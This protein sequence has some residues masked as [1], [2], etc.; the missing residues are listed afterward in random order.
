MSSERN[1]TSSRPYQP[2]FSNNRI[3]QEYYEWLCDFVGVNLP[4]KSYWFLAHTLFK[5]EFFWSVPNDDNRGMDGLK[6][7][8][9]FERDIL[10]RRVYANELRDGPCSMLEM[11]IGLAR[12]MADLTLELGEEDHTREWF[13]VLIR[14]LD[15]E[16]FTDDDYFD[17]GGTPRINFLLDQVLLRTFKRSGKGGLFP[18]RNAKKDQRRVEIWYQMCSYLAENYFSDGQIR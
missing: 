15:M 9:E 17:Y 5:K 11:F 1:Q 6:L 8:E 18:L 10:L 12:R 2:D 16:K 3:V 13:W 14:N 4:D 7:R